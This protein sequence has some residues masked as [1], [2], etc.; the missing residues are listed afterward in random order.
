MHGGDL[1]EFFFLDIGML[2]LAFLFF[3]GL[4]SSII[5]PIGRFRVLGSGLVHGDTLGMPLFIYPILSALVPFFCFVLFSSFLDFQP[6]P[7]CKPD[8][9]SS[10]M[11]RQVRITPS[12]S[13]LF[14]DDMNVIFDIICTSLCSAWMPLLFAWHGCHH[15]LFHILYSIFLSLLGY[16]VSAS[17]FSFSVCS[18]VPC[19]VE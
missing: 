1:D 15:F 5:S 9:L 13:R 10:H 16:S 6:V 18:M 14:S 8:C 11:S 2:P 12:L 3:L 19:G 17:L 7:T 4:L